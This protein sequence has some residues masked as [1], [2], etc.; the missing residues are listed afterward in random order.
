MSGEDSFYC[1]LCKN[2]NRISTKK[3]DLLLICSAC[4]NIKQG[5]VNDSLLYMDNKIDPKDRFRTLIING[6]YDPVNPSVFKECSECKKTKIFKMVRIGNEM[7]QVF[8]CP[9]CPNNEIVQ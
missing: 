1:N 2:V 7:S 3:N 8:L 4:S 6:R 5:D 9:I